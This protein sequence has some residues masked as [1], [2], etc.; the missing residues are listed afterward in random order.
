MHFIMLWST[1]L[2][3]SN[4]EASIFCKPGRVP[5][6]WGHWTLLWLLSLGTKYP[7][8]FPWVF[9][10]SLESFVKA[11]VLQDKLSPQIPSDLQVPC[12][13]PFRKSFPGGLRGTPQVLPSSLLDAS[14][15][16]D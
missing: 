10:S 13:V 15:V 5:Q 16:L 2:L 6:H 7:G 14:V 11:S 3:S 12:L 1:C 4:A 8:V 9:R